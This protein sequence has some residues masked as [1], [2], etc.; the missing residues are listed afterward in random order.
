MFMFIHASNNDSCTSIF[1]FRNSS[2]F[3]LH[4][5]KCW[6]TELLG[7]TLKGTKKRGKGKETR[8]RENKRPVTPIHSYKNNLFSD[9][10]NYCQSRK[11]KRAYLF[12]HA[13]GFVRLVENLIVE[14]REIQ[15][16]TQ[17][18]WMCWCK[19]RGRNILHNCNTSNVYQSKHK[20]TSIYFSLNQTFNSLNPNPNPP[21]KI[22]KQKS[23]ILAINPINS[24]N[25]WKARDY[26]FL[27]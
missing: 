25:N 21:K 4:S 19:I 5:S 20:N 18:Y 26:S 11:I 22:E 7:F 27:L 3:L 16:Q 14:H 12:R 17:P 24:I 15:C 9:R 2:S 13:A 1:P 10:H 23:P 6:E 8:R